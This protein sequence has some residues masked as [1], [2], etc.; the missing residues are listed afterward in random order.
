MLQ[1]KTPTF[2]VYGS[3]IRYS[4]CFEGVH[5]YRSPVKPSRHEGYKHHAAL[6]VCAAD[7]Y[8][9][10][11]LTSKGS[12]MG[13]RTFAKMENAYYYGATEGRETPGSQSWTVRGWRYRGMTLFEREARIEF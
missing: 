3:K 4:V 12:V 2:A 11:M 7:E 13:D 5:R 8:S 9:S 1:Q 10:G 6:R